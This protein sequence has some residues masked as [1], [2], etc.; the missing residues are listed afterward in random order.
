ML[1]LSNITHAKSETYKLHMIEMMFP[2]FEISHE[3]KFCR[4]G[5]MEENRKITHKTLNMT[6]WNK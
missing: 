6:S 2:Y 4:P 5:K 3:I 1:P